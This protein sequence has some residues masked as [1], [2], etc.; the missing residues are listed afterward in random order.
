MML[1]SITQTISSI[2]E[3]EI[4]GAFD[5]AEKLRSFVADFHKNKEKLLAINDLQI[6]C[7]LHNFFIIS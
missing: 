7:L 3:F 2:P 1:K 6:G 5:T 4:A